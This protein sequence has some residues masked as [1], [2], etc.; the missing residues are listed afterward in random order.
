ML[1]VTYIT[2]QLNTKKIIYT[3]GR[4]AELV[5]EI[6]RNLEVFYGWASGGIG[7]RARLKIVFLTD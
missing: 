3:Y 5:Y 1:V 6:A 7:I 2:V 4:V